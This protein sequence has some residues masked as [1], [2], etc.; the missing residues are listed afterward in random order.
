MPKHI[1]T[2]SRRAREISNSPK[3]KRSVGTAAGVILL[4]PGIESGRNPRPRD[5]DPIPIGSRQFTL[6]R[7]W[8]GR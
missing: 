7:A 5:E 6:Q 4:A 8:S 3:F 1:A 2:Q